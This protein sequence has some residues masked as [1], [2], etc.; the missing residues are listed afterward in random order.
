MP[1][2]RRRTKSTNGLPARHL[3]RGAQAAGILLPRSAVSCAA[4]DLMTVRAVTDRMLGALAF[5]I[6]SGQACTPLARFFGHCERWFDLM[7]A[8]CRTAP[9]IM[10]MRFDA[11]D[12]LCGTW[13]LR[14]SSES[15][16][17]NPTQGS[18]VGVPPR[19]EMRRIANPL[20]LNR[21]GPAEETGRWHM[22]PISLSP[23]LLNRIWTGRTMVTMALEIFGTD[24]GRG[25]GIQAD[26]RAPGDPGVCGC[27]AVS[28]A[29]RKHSQAVT[30]EHRCSD[31]PIAKEVPSVPRD[32]EVA[33]VG[34]GMPTGQSMIASV[35]RALDT[36]GGSA[37]MGVAVIAR[38]CQAF[39]AKADDEADNPKR[40]LLERAAENRKRELPLAD[41]VRH[42]APRLA[43]A[44]A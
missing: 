37:A 3:L 1:A 7:G 28:V 22:S 23:C 41:R 12:A 34:I 38:S 19:A 26:L 25:V 16:S 29:M 43:G 6:R 24:G 33:A 4:T 27:T 18:T 39:P 15:E 13:C 42:S 32:V 8:E 5:D 40:L 20:N 36:L 44:E 35:A 30:G 17:R 31:K 2:G 9:H 21:L 11:V 14:S 10:L